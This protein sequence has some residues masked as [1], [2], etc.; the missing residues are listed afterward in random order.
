MSSALSPICATIHAEPSVPARRRSRMRNRLA[1]LL[2]A[3]IVLLCGAGS[4]ASAQTAHFS[5]STPASWAQSSIE[6][7]GSSQQG[8]MAVDGSGN[9]YF[10]DYGQVVLKFTPSGTMSTIGTGL[11]EVS[12]VAVDASGNVYIGDLVNHQVVKEAPSGGAYVQSTVASSSGGSTFYPDGIAVDGGGNIYIED[13]INKQVLKETLSGSIYSQS[14]VVS[15]LQYGISSIAADAAG[16]VYFTDDSDHAAV[17]ETLVSGVYEQTLVGSTGGSCIPTEVAVDTNGNLFIAGKN[18]VLVGGTITYTGAAFVETPLGGSYVQSTIG[19]SQTIPTG[20]AVNGSGN[21]YIS[22]S[23]EPLLEESPVYGNFGTVNLGSASPQPIAMI[24]TFDTAGT[25]GSTAVLTQGAIGLDFLNAGTGTCTA[26]TAYAAGA[27]CTLNV[28]FTP[29]FAGTRNGTAVLYNSAGSAIATGNLQGIGFGPQLRFVPGA[30]STVAS[31]TEPEGV[32]ID[33]SGNVYVSNDTAIYEIH[34]VNGSIPASPTITTPLAT[35][36]RYYSVAVDASGN[37]YT[38][39]YPGNSVIEVEAVNGVIPASPTITTLSSSFNEPEGVAVDKNGN[40]YVADTLNESIKEILAVN[41]SIPAS[42]TIVTLATADCGLYSVAVDLSGNVYFGGCNHTLMQIEAINGTIPPSPTI[43]TLATNIPVGGIAVDGSG[44]VYVSNISDNVVQEILAVNGSIPASP[45][46]ETLSENFFGPESIALDASGNLYVADVFNNRLEKLNFAGPPS[47]AFANTAFGTISADSPQAVTITNIGNAALS[48]PVPST[49]SNP[50]IPANFTLS[51]SG[52]SPCPIVSAGSSEP[53][54]LAA[55]ASCQLFI[56]F[57]PTTEGLLS[58][59][60]VLTDN[61]LNAPSPTYTSQSIGLSGTGTFSLTASP[62]ALTVAQGGSS[63][64]TITVAGISGSVTLGASGL[65]IGITATFSANPTTGASVLTLSANNSVAPGI[66]SLAVTA[67]SGT[68]TLSI[69]IVLTVVTGPS[70]TL[71]ASA[72][73]VSVVQ[74]IS[75][76]S[77]IAVTGLNG[78]TGSVSLAA[79]GLPSYV[80]ATFSPNTTSTSAVLTF[81]AATNAPTGTQNITITGR[82]GALIAS[83]TLS[84]TVTAPQVAAPPP[85]N[86]GSVNIGT[87]SSVTPLTFVFVNGGTL[88]STAVVTQGASGLD[89]TDA[90]TG[91]CAANT[92][93]SPGQSCIV[94]VL[95]TPTLSG[96]RYGAATVEDVYGNVLANGYVQGTGVGPQVNFLPGTESTVANASGGLIAP[97]AIAVDGSGN[98]YIADVASTLVWEA[99]PS[100]GSYTLNTISST[101][102]NQPTGVAVDGNGNVY[103]ADTGNSRVIEETPSPYGGNEITV[104][105]SATSGINSPISLAVDGSGNVY[106]FAADSQ[107]GQTRLYEET[108][109]ATGYIQST[110]PYSGVAQPAGL[111]V[112]GS[113]NIYIVDLGNNQVVEETPSAG[114]YTQSTVPTSGLIQPGGIALDGMGNIYVTDIGGGPVFKETLTS[115]SYIQSTVSTSPLNEPLAV[116]VDGSGNVYVGDAGNSVALKED[117]ADAPSLTFAG[118]AVGSTSPD[119]PQTITVENIGNAALTFPIPSTGNNPAI[120]TNFTLNS[121]GA[122]ACP[123]LGAGS[124]TAGTLAP[125]ASC[126]LSISFAPTAAGALTGSLVLTDNNLNAAAPA[127]TSQTIALSGTATQGT[128]T[129]TWATPAAITY[130]TP[131]SA[132]QLNATSTIAGTF[133]YSP[134]AGTILGAGQQTLTTTFTPTDSTDYTTATA[135]V[136]LTVNQATPTINWATPAAITYGAALSANQLNATSTIA[137]TFTYSPAGG[138]VLNAGTQTLTVSFTP[139]DLTDYAPA[140]ASVGLVVNKAA[141]TITWT[142]PAAISYGTALSA[143]QLDATSTAAG[144]FVYSPAPGTV[145][146][147]GKQTLSVTFTPTNA[148]DFTPSTAKASVTLLVNKATPAITWATPAAINYG[149]PLSATQLNATSTVAGTFAYSPASGTV[150]SAGQQSLNVTF[151]PTNSTDY[152]TATASVILSV[153]KAT[154]TITWGTPKAISYGTALS[155]TQLDATS[156]VA[157]TFT[158]SPA[159]GTVLSAGQ[160]TLNVT[161]KP[162]NTTDYATATASVTLTVNKVT[163]AITWG[164]PKAITYG[165]ALSATQ[166]DATSTVAGTFTY[167]PAAGTVLSVGQQTLTVTLTPTN[168][169]DYATATANVTL[170]VNPAPSFTLAASPASLSVAQGA[171]GKTTIT[172][173]GKNGFAGSVTLAASGLPSGVTAAFGTNPT[174]GTSV[175]TLTASSTATTGTTTVTI[176][177]TSGSLTAS[178]TVA[179]TISC[180]PTTIVPYIYVNGSWSEESAVTV[181]SPSTVVDLGPQP[182]TGGSWSWT[183][184]SGYTS[185]A[186]QI[187]SI[188]LTAGTDSYLATY[189]NASGCKSTETFKITVK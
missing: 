146:A 112:D 44:N 27:T 57:A 187:N 10:A 163:P 171:S 101:S 134:A 175:L 172:V 179:L 56:N 95:F 4:M 157:G 82:S 167:S 125:E 1:N 75:S 168:A 176:N 11:G 23:G 52:A 73:S 48:F 133:T 41:G 8:G 111:A 186:R 156:S 70:F 143:T 135:T 62:T 141:L 5:G 60:L 33:N 180:T 184:P 45:T 77:T 153:N 159:S 97:Y 118:T 76:T 162:T 182:T 7:F 154:P 20:I 132:T 51:E 99:T 128:P 38:A 148:A 63:T 127:Y 136:M 2:A 94:N 96:A 160:Q 91:T 12:A 71:S 164:T 14:T 31:F 30:Q 81:T 93:Y 43:R 98:V 124:S 15:G 121:N 89:F 68:Q 152:T 188:P 37:L 130:G 138:T 84:L 24:F 19:I 142:T 103:I 46:I 88:G 169:T 86:F 50:S 85:A 39:P 17:K 64:S 165:T 35:G 78:F 122:S 110:V 158:Y 115:G 149:T 42:P 22:S 53:G 34:A 36:G 29:K 105:D 117:L 170:T 87:P 100:A 155:A 55:G 59:S 3:L 61:N 13:Q 65:Y 126:Q 189:T 47:L 92:F 161:F 147:V 74:G 66:Y 109:S 177:G 79:S 28:T 129:I 145:L 25:L 123:V 140:T 166:L 21:L 49:G 113:G 107:T 67:T 72:P 150:L 18:Q 32:A 102:L 54:S 6:I 40:V 139:T 185:T 26:G 181:S 114:S 174:T 104:A 9:I 80:T 116:A 173:S 83:T 144:T 183:G 120:A 119:S 69:P 178:T 108:P 137:G 151:T 58:G 131:L 16:N 106:F 90:G